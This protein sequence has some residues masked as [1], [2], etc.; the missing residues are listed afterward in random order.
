MALSRSADDAPVSGETSG[1][2]GTDDA[3]DDNDADEDEQPIVIPD[4]SSSPPQ[5][6][7]KRAR[8]KKVVK[9]S[10]DDSRSQFKA[11]VASKVVSR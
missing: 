4:E 10:G 6:P 11:G 7:T 8:N 9:D 2:P 1:V 5:R 3:G